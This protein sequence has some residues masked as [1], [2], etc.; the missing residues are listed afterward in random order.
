MGICCRLRNPKEGLC[1]NLEELDG[2]GGGREVQK[3]RDI[4]VPMADS[5]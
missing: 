4:C 3:S 1:I 5:C 2:V